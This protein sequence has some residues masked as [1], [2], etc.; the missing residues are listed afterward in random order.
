MSFKW[1][2]GVV[3]VVAQVESVQNCNVLTAVIGHEGSFPLA[4]YSELYWLK[5]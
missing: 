1:M 2:L 4:H 3:V 5:G